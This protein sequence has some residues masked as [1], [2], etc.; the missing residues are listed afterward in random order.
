MIAIIGV[1]VALILPAVQ[2]AREAAN[3]AKCMNN[4]KQL[5]LAAQEYHDSFSSFPSGWYCDAER[6]ATASRPVRRRSLHVER[7]DRACSSSSSRGTS[8]TRST[9][10]SRPTSTRA[11]STDASGGR[12]TASSAR[13]TARPH[14]RRPRA[15]RRRADHDRRKFGPSRLSRQHGRR[16]SIRR[17]ASRPSTQRSTPAT[18]YDNGMTYQNSEVSIADI[19]DG[20]SN[21]I[22]IGETLDGH[23]ARRHE[24]L[25]PD[26]HRP[27]DQQADPEPNGR[28]LL[29]LLD[30]QAPRPWSTSPTA[31]AASARSPTRSTSW[32]SSS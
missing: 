20:T 5:G 30:E 28:Q 18:I 24:L 13:R 12:S 29:H 31:T 14:G 32:S 1:L 8:T 11:I 25:R 26:D 4:L 16:A 22:L 21:T 15:S 7:P 19:T 17:T 9:S 3:R 6:P 2:S 27:D 10:T 23:L